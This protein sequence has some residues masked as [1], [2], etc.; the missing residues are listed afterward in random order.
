MTVQKLRAIGI[1][2]PKPLT[3]D[4]ADYADKSSY[5]KRSIWTSTHDYL[6]HP[7]HPRYPRWFFPSLK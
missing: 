2:N 4:Y 3:A 7:L 1:I 5:P 6:G